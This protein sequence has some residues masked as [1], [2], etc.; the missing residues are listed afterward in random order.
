MGTIQ[1]SPY[2]IMEST[3]IL[4]VRVM[5]YGD[6]PVRLLSLFHTSLGKVVVQKEAPFTDPPIAKPNL[7]TV[8]DVP[9]HFQSWDLLFV[10]SQHIQ[11]AITA[12]M[13][14]KR[15]NRILI[16]S[17]VN[18]YTP[19]DVLQV[20]KVDEKGTVNEFNSNELDSGHMAVLLTVWACRRAMLGVLLSSS[21]NRDSLPP[22]VDHTMLP[23][24]V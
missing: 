14:F 11:D 18:K 5:R 23:F 19:D 10:E 20:K 6:Q 9:D 16:E 7:V 13:E 24:S 3:L 17:A 12:Y 15:S 21:V 8:V 4:D 22:D 1:H 2:F